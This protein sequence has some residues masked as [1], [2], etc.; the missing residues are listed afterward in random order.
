MVDEEIMS[1][2]SPDGNLK[3]VKGTR[4]KRQLSA[5]FDKQA[6]QEPGEDSSHSSSR[7]CTN[8]CS[9]QPGT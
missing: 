4:F 8:R 1:V 6:T 7:Y 3:R 2:P 5:L 9:R